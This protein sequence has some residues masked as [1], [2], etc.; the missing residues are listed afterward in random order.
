MAP[1]CAFSPSSPSSWGKFLTQI[2]T[3]IFIFL[4]YDTSP[5]AKGTSR[6]EQNK[7]NNCFFFSQLVCDHNADLQRGGCQWNREDPGDGGGCATGSQGLP[8]RYRGTAEEVRNPE[9]RRSQR[10]YTRRPRQ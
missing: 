6:L 2:K 1:P 9:P 5:T 3:H 10:S 8:R 7:F 4:V